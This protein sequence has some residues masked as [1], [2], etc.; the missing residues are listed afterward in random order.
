MGCTDECPGS[1]KDAGKGKVEDRLPARVG[2]I[3]LGG[4]GVRCLVFEGRFVCEG[5]GN[6]DRDAERRGEQGCSAERYPRGD[7]ILSGRPKVGDTEPHRLGERDAGGGPRG[8]SCGKRT[9]KEGPGGVQG[10]IPEGCC[11]KGA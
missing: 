10:G 5:V 2:K 6:T 1:R 9:R 7:K 4:R 8:A 11:S 3:D